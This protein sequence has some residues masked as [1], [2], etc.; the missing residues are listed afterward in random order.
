MATNLEKQL[1]QDFAEILEKSQPKFAATIKQLVGMGRP[2][3]EIVVI[4]KLS[5]ASDLILGLVEGAATHYKAKGL[6]K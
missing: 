6:S 5:G 4:C 3:R 1:D 2:I